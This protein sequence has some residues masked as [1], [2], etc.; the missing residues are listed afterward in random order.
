MT[1]LLVQVLPEVPRKA[2]DVLKLLPKY[3]LFA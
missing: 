2:Y 3:D 1:R